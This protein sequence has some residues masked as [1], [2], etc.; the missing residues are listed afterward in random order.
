MTFVSAFTNVKRLVLI[1]LGIVDIDV[2]DYYYTLG[3]RGMFGFG[4]ILVE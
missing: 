2:Q 3:I 1:N 4:R